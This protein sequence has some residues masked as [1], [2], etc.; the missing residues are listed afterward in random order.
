[1]KIEIIRAEKDYKTILENKMAANNLGSAWSSMKSIAGIS[2]SKNISTVESD[3]D[4]A[5]AL[6]TLFSRFDTSVKSGK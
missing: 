5:N 4:L 1:M 6:N 2:N 3:P